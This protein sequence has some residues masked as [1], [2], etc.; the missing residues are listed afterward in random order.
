M[1]LPAFATWRRDVIGASWRAW[2]DGKLAVIGDATSAH[3][4]R[5][6]PHES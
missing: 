5:L 2:L 4:V 1:H 6:V 3:G